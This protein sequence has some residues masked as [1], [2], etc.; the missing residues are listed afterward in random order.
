MPRTT[1]ASRPRAWS[2]IDVYALLVP[3]VF[4]LLAIGPELLG[5]RELLTVDLLTGHMPWQ[6]LNGNSAPAA[7]A[8]S[9]DTIDSVLPAT[10]YIRDTV[11]AGHLPNWQ[12]LVDGG[13]PLG[14]TPDIG[15]LDPLSLPYW[16]LPLWLAP[17]FVKLFE[18]IA[19]IGGMYLFL[20]RLNLSR[21][22]AS[23][24]GIVFAG[25]G[26]MVVWTGW[27]QSRTAALIPVLFWSVERL[28]QRSRLVDAALVA[29]AVASMVFAGFPEITGFA[30]YAVGAYLIVRLIARHGRSVRQIGRGVGL[31]AFGLVLGAAI[32]AVELL[33]F[34][35][36]LGY[37]D[38]SYRAQNSSL[39]LPLAAL[40][41]TV[42][43]GANGTCINSQILGAIN[44]VELI[45]YVGSAAA[46][47]AVLA[48]STILFHRRA[49]GVPPV[50]RGVRTYL[51]VTLLLVI[52]L[53]WIGGEL[54]GLAQHFP[55]FSNNYIARIRSIF[56]FLMAVLA[57]YGLDLL[58]RRA[59]PA[60]DARGFAARRVHGWASGTSP[61]PPPLRYAFFA[62]VWLAAALSGA[63]ILR[64]AHHEALAFKYWTL[65][66]PTL[67]V[68]AV[69]IAATLVAAVLVCTRVPALRV[70]GVIV[71]PALI[72]GQGAVFFRTFLPGNSTK[73]FYPVT[74]T[75]RFLAEHLGDNRFEGSNNTMYPATALYYGLRVATGHETS[76]PQW[77]Q[78]L[79]AV[80]PATAQSPTNFALP[81]SINAT[82]AG[83]QPILDRMGVTYFV[84]DPSQ[85]VGTP[86]VQPPGDGSLRLPPAG[87][88][89]CTV[90]AG[91]LR[92]IVFTVRDALAAGA[93][94]DIRVQA[95]AHS[96]GAEVTGGRDLGTSVAGGT[97]VTV[98]LAGE[99][100]T[101]AT[102]V[103]L[104][105]TGANA[106]AS[107]VADAGALSCT[108]IRPI[109][110]GLRLVYSDEGSIVFQRLT[111]LPRIR[112]APSS[113]VISQQAARIS[114]L[115]AGV[116]DD[117]V[118]LDSPGPATSGLPATVAVQR[119]DGDD[120]DVKVDAQGTGY[121]VVADGMQSPG[122]SVTVDG[123]PGTLVPADHAMVA[124]SVTAGVHTIRMHYTAPRQ[125]AG[126][127]ISLLALLLAAALPAQA[128]R[129]RRRRSPP[130]DPA[131]ELVRR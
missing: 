7:Q 69:L 131:E 125:E 36:E 89:S 63:V 5:L 126:A 47:L 90:A 66:K 35:S 12:S 88:A 93:G 109:D 71:I 64:S 96:G 48:I 92:A 102:T 95:V 44:P 25:S 10:A 103:T 75:H 1:H 116:P 16:I 23:T 46:V 122:W 94:Q 9:T 30:L 76:S 123:K 124:V 127:V 32:T 26:F 110:D 99:A 77:Q 11:F 100:L 38:L 29:V 43:P 24:A 33:P 115:A 97:Q 6:A 4:V 62:A 19:A 73:N 85:V 113:T 106:A 67:T 65:L 87:A 17:A 86:L 82:D 13:G 39:R 72:V 98:P 56:G 42:D 61:V 114:A 18:F 3:I 49:A 40:L 31:A 120:I 105:L 14:S 84:V 107:L 57:G 2:W 60:T 8:C 129:R 119:D 51:V 37:T 50:D 54:L 83:H 59:G 111:A 117:E 128:W 91:S 80:A 108:P 74:A 53:C 112:W 41:T 104:Q 21:L 52:A 22:A 70:I 45:S 34:A 55:V 28:V 79:E 68:P 58:V 101:A 121:L 27:P 78:L 81:A 20:R 15:M 130:L 118:V